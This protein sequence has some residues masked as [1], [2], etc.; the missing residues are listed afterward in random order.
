MGHRKHVHRQKLLVQRKPRSVHEGSCSR[1]KLMSVM[2]TN[3]CALPCHE[4]ELPV[5]AAF[6]TG[7]F[8]AAIAPQH[9]VFQA[10]F[11]IRK[12]AGEPVETG[13]CVSPSPNMGI[14]QCCLKFIIA[15]SNH[16]ALQDD[17][18]PDGGRYYCCH[19]R[20]CWSRDRNRPRELVSATVRH[21]TRNSV[22]ARLTLQ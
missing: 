1:V 2:L 16:V 4:V 20:D 7:R 15:K 17:S 14:P 10:G 3:V 6:W 9:H 5:L 21:R 13:H 19:Y 11:V 22:C 12:L 8:R 18:A